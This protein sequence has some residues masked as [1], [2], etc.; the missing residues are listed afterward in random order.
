MYKRYLILIYLL[1]QMTYLQA[2]NLDTAYTTNE[3][4]MY[5]LEDIYIKLTTGSNM[6]LLDHSLS[7]SA[8]PGATMHTLNQIFSNIPSTNDLRAGVS[9]GVLYL[10]NPGDVKN[11]V[12]YGA[13]GTEYSGTYTSDATAVAGDIRIDK[14]GYANGSKIT[15]TL[16]TQGNQTGV[17]GNPVINLTNGIYEA[18][19]ATAQDSD[20]LAGNVRK[21]VNVFGTLGTFTG[22]PI[23]TGQVTSYRAGDDAIYR[24]GF[25]GGYTN[26]DGSWDG[27]ARFT[28]T[29]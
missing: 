18:K 20:L 27:T 12:N 24:K 15:G 16:S 23:K 10:P 2:G 1:F 4:T 19:T 26:A 28:D 17:N 3:K 5:T 7:P 25:T 13:S 6:A 14:T 29:I 8:P 22:I 11:S 9:G 21:G